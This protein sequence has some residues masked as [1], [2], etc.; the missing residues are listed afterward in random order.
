MMNILQKTT[1]ALFLCFSLS[2][3]VIAQQIYNLDLESSIELAK[4]KSKTMLIL[5]QSLKKAS[6]DL[7]A[8]TSS[9]KTHVTMDFILPQYTETIRQ[10][11]DTAGITFYPVRQNQLS[12]YMTINPVS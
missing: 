9:F 3:I 6:F 12:S 4:V 7:K 2:P 10:F 8:A 5:Q 1:S 11:E